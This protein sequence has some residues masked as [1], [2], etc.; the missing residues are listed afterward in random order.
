M[1]ARKMRREY[2]CGDLGLAANAVEHSLEWLG[3]SVRAIWGAYHVRLFLRF[4]RIREA[5]TALPDQ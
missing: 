4:T 1:A 3:N 2:G 5:V